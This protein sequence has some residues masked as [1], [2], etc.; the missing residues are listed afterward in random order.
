MNIFLIKHVPDGGTYYALLPF[1]AD[2]EFSNKRNKK[3]DAN[4]WGKSLNN[5]NELNEHSGPMK[6]VFAK[7]GVDPNCKITHHRTQAVLL[8]ASKG[9]DERQ[10]STYTKHKTDKLSTAFLPDC[11]RTALKVMSGFSITDARYGKEEHVAFPTVNGLSAQ[12]IYKF[13]V[14]LVPKFKLYMSQA[15]S[16]PA[17][18]DTSIC[19]RTFLGSVLPFL[20]ET[21]LQNG[22]YFIRDYPTN[23][24]SLML[25]VGTCILQWIPMNV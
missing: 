21:V 17:L 14:Y 12:Y 11:E 22:I 10:I 1:H 6:E 8:G 23:E 20:V 16:A 25:K 15:N 7:T 13:T 18:A 5:Y 19:C 24:F 2:C 4:W 9:L 3:Q